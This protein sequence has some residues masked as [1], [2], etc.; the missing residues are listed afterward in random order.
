MI[1]QI[2]Q[3]KKMYGGNIIFENLSLGVKEKERIGIVGRNGG[4][5]STLLRL[6]A[7]ITKQDEGSIHWKKATT[8][9]YLEQIPN[10]EEGIS[11]FDV[12]KQSNQEI[13]ALE[14][15]IQALGNPCSIHSRRKNWQ[16]LF[17]LTERPRSVLPCLAGMN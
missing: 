5:K 1:C 9:G 17:K 15:Q 12:L 8:I 2:N 14:K 11:V 13:V 3:V 4:G 6:M 16:Q 10:P 7:G